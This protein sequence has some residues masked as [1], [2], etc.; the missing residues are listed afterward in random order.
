M[1][2]GVQV[3]SGIVESRILEAASSDRRKLADLVLA[4]RVESALLRDPSLW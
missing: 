2:E 3:A 1:A 4:S